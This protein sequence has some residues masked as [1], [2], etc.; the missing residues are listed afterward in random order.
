MHNWMPACLATAVLVLGANAQAQILGAGYDSPQIHTLPVGAQI[1]TKETSGDHD[2]PVTAP[3]IESAR[4][5]TLARLPVLVLRDPVAIEPV[6]D[7]GDLDPQEETEVSRLQE[8]DEPEE[9]TS[10]AGTHFYR[11][12]RVHS[13][14][15]MRE[16]I[17][18]A[19]CLE[20]SAARSFNSE[21]DQTNCRIVVGGFMAATCIAAGVPG[22]PP[23]LNIVWGALCITLSAAVLA[24]IDRICPLEPPPSLKR[25]PEP[26]HRDPH[27]T[28]GNPRPPLAGN[29][30]GGND[31][32]S[33]DARS[34]SSSIRSSARC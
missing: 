18:M 23:P 11:L 12:W 29:D 34:Y 5:T 30:P 2:V 20:G 26:I 10:A 27:P 4:R 25:P 6:E 21:R 24:D 13:S 28:W 7:G 9:E 1:D 16:R 19:A 22:Q 8:R 3:P 32:C 17:G 31:G 14:D 33:W 15:G